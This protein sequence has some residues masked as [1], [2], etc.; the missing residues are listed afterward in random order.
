MPERKAK[1]LTDNELVGAL[2]A[3]IPDDQ[4]EESTQV[5]PEREFT[6]PDGKYP[7]RLTGVMTGRQKEG[8]KAVWFGLV[9]VVT[10][11]LAKYAGEKIVKFITLKETRNR[12]V[13]EV[14]EEL[15]SD[16]Q[17]LGYKAE[18]QAA[19]V[20]G[21]KKEDVP[22]AIDWLKKTKP[23]AMIRTNTSTWEDDATGEERSMTFVRVLGPIE[24]D[25]GDLS[26]DITAIPLTDLA[27]SADAKEGDPAAETELSRRAQ[28]AGID[29][30]AVDS[31]SG[32][33][34]YPTWQSVANAIEQGG[35]SGTE[36]PFPTS[37]TGSSSDEPTLGQ[38]ADEGDAEAI[39]Q[40]TYVAEEA[41]SEG[42]EWEGSWDELSYTEV[43]EQIAQFRLG[44][45]GDPSPENPSSSSSTQSSSPSNTRSTTTTSSSEE[46][47]EL[48]RLADEEADNAAFDKLEQL[49]GE[50]GIDHND[51][52]FKT[53]TELAQGILDAGPPADPSASST[54]TTGSGEPQDGV[55]PQKGE[56]YMFAF[57]KGLEPEVCE[58]KTS[59]KSKR[60]CSLTR[61]SDSHLFQ[62]VSWDK[63]GERV[64]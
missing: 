27:A 57:R 40:I 35:G 33:P 37:T 12:T 9:F 50:A 17:L 34:L 4:W 7:V 32:Q 41:E 44:Q 29:P 61:L 21:M 3:A 24:T 46:L 20:E 54:P 53:W 56:K 2:D 51:P 23:T 39:E 15:L 59:N 60:T 64:D 30:D 13:Q 58:V 16:F 52:Q 28:E 22:A 25:S 6:G 18:G 47:L 8:K 62:E 38:L 19:G 31:A 1:G 42:L 5:K 26:K 45:S 11:A 43:E 63:L 14:L 48:G 49:A 55:N 36:P 10:K